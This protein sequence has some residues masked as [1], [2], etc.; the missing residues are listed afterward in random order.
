MKKTIS[1]MLVTVSKT[2]EHNRINV[3]KEDYYE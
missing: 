2:V 1:L 3:F